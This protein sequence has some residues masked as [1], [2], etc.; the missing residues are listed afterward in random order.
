MTEE[1]LLEYRNSYSG[2]LNSIKEIHKSMESNLAPHLDICKFAPDIG[3]GTLK[4]YLNDFAS[5][6]EPLDI[7]CI[8]KAKKNTGFLAGLLNCY[9]NFIVTPQTLYLDSTAIKFSEI[10]S[11]DYRYTTKTSLFGNTKIES[12]LKIITKNSDTAKTFKGD[13]AVQ[14]IAEFL[15]AIVKA[16]NENPPEEIPAKEY[17]RSKLIE[18]TLN[19][20]KISFFNPGFNHKEVNSI[21]IK[22]GKDELKAS[23]AANYGSYKKELYL[24]NE[25]LYF[26]SS[27]DWERIPYTDLLK[28][29]YKEEENLNSEGEIEVAY[30]TSLYDKNNKIVFSTSENSVNEDK[31][32][33]DFFSMIISDATGKEVKTEVKV[34]KASRKNRE[35]LDIIQAF[36]ESH[37]NLSWFES[38]YDGGLEVHHP[39]SKEAGRI[40]DFV[41]CTFYIAFCVDSIWIKTSWSSHGPGKEFKYNSISKA[42]LKLDG[43]YPS[44]SLYDKKG[45][46]C[47]YYIP[48]KQNYD[49]DSFSKSLADVINEIVSKLTGKQTKTECI[50]VRP[51]ESIIQSDAL[52]DSKEIRDNWN[53]LLNKWND[54]FSKEAPIEF[55]RLTDSEKKELPEWIIRKLDVKHKC[56]YLHS[57]FREKNSEET[58]IRAEKSINYYREYNDYFYY[59]IENSVLQILNNNKDFFYFPDT[60]SETTKYLYFENKYHS[61]VKFKAVSGASSIESKSEWQNYGPGFAR[62]DGLPGVID[63]ESFFKFIGKEEFARNYCSFEERLK[64]SEEE[65]LQK[66]KDGTDVIG[67]AKQEAEQEAKQNLMDDLNNW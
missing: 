20:L 8:G 5:K 9:T 30:E 17:P 29:V 26:F 62:D 60:Y 24:S 47:F 18:N 21:I 13:I 16:F 41:G 40:F 52:S 4:N 3:D 54:I 43:K 58:V 25:N 2:F 6:E 61:S 23:F 33:A 66:A 34:K 49:W 45:Q 55:R 44:L 38:R 56:D 22:F 48:S 12:F 65:G 35:V 11:I 39:V 50:D 19:D 42:C 32:F 63:Y 37:K 14:V 27:G 15:N 46:Q 7:L 64:K 31:K 67:K 10:E 57:Y 59:F 51:I 36:R 28:A 53:I 1:E